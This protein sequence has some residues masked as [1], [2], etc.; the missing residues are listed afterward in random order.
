MDNKMKVFIA[1]PLLRNTSSPVQFHD[2]QESWVG[3]RIEG[4]A[5]IHEWLGAL[6]GVAAVYREFATANGG[7]KDRG[8]DQVIYAAPLILKVE[9]ATASGYLVSLITSE[10]G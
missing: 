4:G 7:L 10:G 1:P 9:Q 6:D 8:G 5:Y 3:T 2:K